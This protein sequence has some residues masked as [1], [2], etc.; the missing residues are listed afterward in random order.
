LY[1]DLAAPYVRAK[2]AITKNSKEARQFLSAGVAAALKAHV[3]RKAPQAPV[4]NMPPGKEVMAAVL[5]GDVAQARTAWLASAANDPDE[6]LR[7]EQSDFLQAGNDK[8]EVSDF[9]E[10]RHTSGAW[11]IEDGASPKEVQKLMRHATIT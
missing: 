1:F 4:F 6:R 2:A 8:G 11:Y 3:A 7:R 10:L 9:H 5:L